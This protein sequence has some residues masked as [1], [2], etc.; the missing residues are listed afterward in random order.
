MSINA[1]LCSES[2]LREAENFDILKMYLN[3]AVTTTYSKGAE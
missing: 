2:E 3:T 1:V